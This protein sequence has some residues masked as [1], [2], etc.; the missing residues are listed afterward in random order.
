VKSYPPVTSILFKKNG[1]T[2]GGGN[3]IYQVDGQVHRQRSVLVFDSVSSNDFG[4]YT[5]IAEN[6][7]G[8]RQ[9][10]IRLVKTCKC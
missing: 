7:E 10:E 8:E 4:A 9:G 6:S 5:C 1:E 3:I 2:L